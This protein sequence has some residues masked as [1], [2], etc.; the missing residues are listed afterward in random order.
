[1]NIRC[2]YFVLSVM[3]TDDAWLCLADE[4]ELGPRVLEV[5]DSTDKGRW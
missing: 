5:N 1:M 2:A 4:Q 3:S